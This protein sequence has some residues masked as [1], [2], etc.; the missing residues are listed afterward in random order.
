MLGACPT[1]SYRGEDRATMAG[2]GKKGD[3]KSN[4]DGDEKGE[5]AREPPR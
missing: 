2:E 4:G 5:R 3:G 1:A